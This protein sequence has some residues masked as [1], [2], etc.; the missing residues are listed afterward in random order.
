MPPDTRTQEQKI[1]GIIHLVS[2]YGG[3]AVDLS[4]MEAVE[5]LREIR[6]AIEGMM[7]KPSVTPQWHMIEDEETKSY[8]IVNTESGRVYCRGMGDGDAW[9]L[10]RHLN[11]IEE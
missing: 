7:A 5:R 11:G 4:A 1:D 3:M 9:S 6:L 10:V 8:M 2:A